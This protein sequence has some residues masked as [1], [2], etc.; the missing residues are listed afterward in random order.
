MTESRMATVPRIADHRERDGGFRHFPVVGIRDH[1][2]GRL[3]PRIEIA[4]RVL[5]TS[6]DIARRA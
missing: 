1:L 3:Q 5:E 4:R 6:D 2:H